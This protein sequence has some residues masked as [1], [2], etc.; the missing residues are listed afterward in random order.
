MKSQISI[1][2]DIIDIQRFQEKPLKENQKFYNSNFSETELKHCKKFSNPYIHLAGIFAA[3]EAVIKCIG[4]PIPLSNIKLTWNGSG[5]PT[6]M[7]FPERIFLNITISHTN[8]LAIAVA[9]TL[10]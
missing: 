6:A 2:T 3:K 9:V 5:N 8:Q 7:I 1:G 4:K 10:T